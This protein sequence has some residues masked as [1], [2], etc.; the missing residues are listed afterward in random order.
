MLVRLLGRMDPTLDVAPTDRFIL[1]NEPPAAA[2]TRLR[3]LFQGQLALV[4]P[5][6]WLGYGA[7]SLAIYFS[8]S[9]GPL[10]LEELKV[11]RETAAL[12]GSASGMLGAVAGLMLMRFTDRLGPIAVAFY[13]APAP[14][15]GSAG[16]GRRAPDRRRPRSVRDD[17]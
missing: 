17:R 11:P 10:V 4:T 3:D 13:P 7:S 15:R 2:R 1:G 14:C 6:L 12:I 16:S 5:L 8:S 9:W